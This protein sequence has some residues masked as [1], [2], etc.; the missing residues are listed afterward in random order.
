MLHT[1]TTVL[2]CFKNFYDLGSVENRP[3]LG[4]PPVSKQ[5]V[6]TVNYYFHQPLTSSLKGEEKVLGRPFSTTHNILIKVALMFPYKISKVHLVKQRTV[7]N[8][9]PFFSLLWTTCRRILVSYAGLLYLMTLPS[10]SRDLKTLRK[11]VSDNMKPKRS[12]IT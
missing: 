12:P 2:R 9:L 10:T 11:L 4:W 7:F 1:R 5:K 8:G 3:G 6:Q